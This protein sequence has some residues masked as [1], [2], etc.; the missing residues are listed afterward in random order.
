MNFQSGNAQVQDTLLIAEDLPVTEIL[1]SRLRSIKT[2]ALNTRIITLDSNSIRNSRNI[3][4][5]DILLQNNQ[6]FVASNENFSQDMRISIRGFGMRSA[7][8]IRAVKLVVDGIPESTPDGQ[9]DIENIDP[10]NIKSINV[11]KGSASGEYSNANGGVIEITTNL[12]QQ[13]LELDY[14][15]TVGSYGLIKNNSSIGTNLGNV[16]LFGSYSDTRY[17]GYRAHNQFKSKNYMAKVFLGSSNNSLQLIYNGFVS[18]TANDPGGLTL[19]QAEE[20]RRQARVQNSSFLAGETVKQN[21]IS[22]QGKNKIKSQSSLKYAGFYTQKKFS[23][24]LPF[25]NGGAVTFDRS[26]YGGQLSYTIPQLISS[27]DRIILGIEYDGQQDLRKRFDNLINSTGTLRLDQIEEFSTRGFY[28]DYESKIRKFA[29]KVNSRI[30][31]INLYLTDNFLSDG[32][33]GGFKSFIP[34]SGKVNAAFSIQKHISISSLVST[35]FETP[36]L[37]EISTNPNT[38]GFNDLAPARTYTQELGINSKSE[39]TNF[40]INVYNTTSSN[41]LIPYQVASQI[42]RI[43]FRNGGKS[44]RRGIEASFVTEILKSFKV[45]GS[46]NLNK[47]EVTSNDGSGNNLAYKIPGIPENQWQLG[48]SSSAVKFINLS[49][50]FQGFSSYFADDLNAVKIDQV[51]RLLFSASSSFKTSSLIVNPS[52]GLNKILS[53]EYNSNVFINAA[54]GRYYEPGAFSM[55]YLNLAVGFYK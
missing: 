4:I 26:F 20:N 43:F 49:I 39:K 27:Q 44:I 28:L 6:L 3:S 24:L 35:G 18:P 15:S 41:E 13:K 42:G 19:M 48:L 17:E 46:A 22:I 52:F 2:S 29:F 21:K 32:D 7:F 14:K 36:T 9:T 10:S 40:D 54:G 8:G 1:G 12:P 33:Q 16:K 51:S 38:S 30:E 25:A 45:N 37:A 23:N 47:F 31:K 53:N 55:V 50:N 11:L 5:G 34:I